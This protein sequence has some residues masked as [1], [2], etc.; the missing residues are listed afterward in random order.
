DLSERSDQKEVR[1]IRLVFVCWPFEDQGSSLVIQGYSEAARA[2]GHEV[3]VY[4]CPYDKIPLNYSLAVGSADAVVFL[5]EWT[6]RQY[7]GDRRGLARLVGKVPRVRRVVDDGDGNYNDVIT[8]EGDVNHEDAAS[9]HRWSQVC[10]SLSDK[11]C[12]PTL[13][14]IRSNVRPF[15]F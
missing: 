15:L 3:T 2:L 5:F 4:A 6:T 8:V 7:S 11:I 12:Q 1:P 13:H 10:D 14:P 9:S